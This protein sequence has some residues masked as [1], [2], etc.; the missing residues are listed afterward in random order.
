MKP[1]HPLRSYE[2]KN[3]YQNEYSRNNTLI[4]DEYSR[5]NFPEKIKDGTYVINLD[6]HEE[7]DTPWV[8]LLCKRSGIVYFDSFG[9]EHVPKEIKKFIGNKEIIANIFRAQ[10]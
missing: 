7:V 10:F 5:N 2:I 9:V 8:A 3:Y 6:E 1:P 4:S